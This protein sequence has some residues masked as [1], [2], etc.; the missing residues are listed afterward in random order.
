M[1]KKILFYTISVVLFLHAGYDDE[2]GIEIDTTSIINED[3]SKFSN[4]G[5]GGSFQ[6]SRYVVSPRFDLNYVNVSDFSGVDSLFKTSINGV[7][8]FENHTRVLPYTLFGLGYE[9]VTPEIKDSFE[10]HI[11]AQM[12]LGLAYKL[13]YG[14]KIK[15]EGKMLQILGGDKEENEMILAFGMSFPLGHVRKKAHIHKRRRAMPHKIQP[16]IPILVDEPFANNCTIKINQ[17]DKDRDGIED[18]LDQ[19]PNTP[20]NFIVDSYGCPIKLTLRINFAI[21]S[22]KIKSDSIGKIDRFSKFL[23]RNKGSFVRVIGHTDSVGTDEA[24][25]A[26]SI[27]RANS[28]VNRLLELG[29]SPSRIKAE[30]RGERQPLV[31]NYTDEG[32]SKNRRIEI[33]LSYPDKYRGVD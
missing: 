23:F 6:M 17:P 12:G 8:E 29:V 32:K 28:V 7:Y 18:R 16:L 21:G 10:S 15:F 13:D 33:I 1:F 31:S 3:S 4:Y 25:M 27:Q 22:A 2:F 30:G 19:C 26:L 5:I 11:F 20:C 9:K 14:Y 24:N